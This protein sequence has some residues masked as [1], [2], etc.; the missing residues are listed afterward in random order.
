M[1]VE[2]AETVEPL[3]QFDPEDSWTTM[4]QFHP[5]DTMTVD[6]KRR[7]KCLFFT[8]SALSRASLVLAA[9]VLVS[10]AVVGVEAVAECMCEL[11]WPG[12]ELPV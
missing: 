1:T 5:E 2:L 4:G 10:F 8:S 12:Q 9:F 6:R 11:Q 7:R 3:R